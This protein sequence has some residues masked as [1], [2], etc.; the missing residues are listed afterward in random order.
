MMGKYLETDSSMKTQ[1]KKPVIGVNLGKNK[2][3]PLDS[4]QD[5]VDGVVKFGGIADYLVINISSPNTSG[6]R[7]L[8]ERDHM[9]KLIKDVINARNNLT[10]SAGLKG[11]PVVIKIAPDLTKEDKADIAKAVM[12]SDLK[13]DGLIVSNTTVTRPETLKNSS[14]SE[15]GGLSGAPLKDLSRQAI[16]DMYKL[17]KG[18]IPIIGVGGVSS[19]QD[20]YDKITA[21]ASLIQLYTSFVYIGPPVAAKI[22]NELEQLLKKNGFSNI[23]EAVGSAH[24]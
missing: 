22:N 14:K 9:M 20:A 6:L 12:T 16:F 1:N 17:T 21:G 24:H 10:N 23:K 2:D 19:G 4:V 11:P 3:S 8:Q 7:S 18:E 15:T 5:Y 13:I